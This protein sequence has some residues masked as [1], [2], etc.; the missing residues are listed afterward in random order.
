MTDWSARDR[1]LGMDQ[2][3][4]RRDFLN[5]VA[6]TFGGA[7]VAQLG[8]GGLA[9]ALTPVPYPPK[10]TGLRGHSEGAMDIGHALRDGTFWQSAP[11]AEASG[12]SHDLV[13]VGGGISGLAAAWFFR[14]Q[15]PDAKVLILENND[16]FGGHARRNEFTASNGRT[17]IGYGGSQSLQTPSYFSELVSQTMKDI[18]IEVERFEEFYDADW[19]AELEE[20]V[21]FRKEAFGADVLVKMGE[22]AA[23]WVPNTPLNDKARADLI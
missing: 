19:G 4:S 12:E 1:E 22:T 6:L 20:A 3:I 13:V 5:G 23:D 17:V 8:L 10:L 9:K 15:R 14:R 18:G 7:A 2:P 11:A 16:D 21:L